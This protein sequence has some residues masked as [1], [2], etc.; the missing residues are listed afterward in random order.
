MKTDMNKNKCKNCEGTGK[1][2][3][4]EYIY[5]RMEICSWCKG[6]GIFELPEKL[7]ICRWTIKIDDN[8]PPKECSRN[9]NGY[10]EIDE[11]KCNC[12]CYEPQ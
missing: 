11:N 12:V 3:V 10:C 6:T 4:G 8:V 7:Y 1:M 9:K 2:E 5:A